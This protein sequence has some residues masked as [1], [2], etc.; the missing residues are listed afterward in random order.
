[1]ANHRVNCFWQRVFSASNFQIVVQSPTVPVLQFKYGCIFVQRRHETWLVKQTTGILA[2]SLPYLLIFSICVANLTT[3]KHVAFL[4]QLCLM[5][6]L[7]SYFTLSTPHSREIAPLTSPLFPNAPYLPLPLNRVAFFLTSHHQ[8]IKTRPT[9]WILRF[10]SFSCPAP[11][12]IFYLNPLLLYQL[13][14]IHIHYV[15]SF[16]LIN[17]L[18]SHTVCAT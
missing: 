16:L 1:M 17:W 13:L 4:L 7:K 8:A 15:Q 5:A 6:L 12:F 9:S 10:Y 11:A 14:L 18:I 3:E 2:T